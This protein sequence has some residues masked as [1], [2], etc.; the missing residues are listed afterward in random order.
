MTTASSIVLHI[1]ANDTSRETRTQI[2]RDAGFHV[3]EDLGG[4]LASALAVTHQPAL[5]LLDL[6][7]PDRDG[8]QLCRELKQSA[9]AANV[10]VLAILAEEAGENACAIAAEFGADACLREPVEPAVL[11]S[12]VRALIGRRQAVPETKQ[13]D[14]RA[15]LHGYEVHGGAELILGSI[16]DP[17]LAL[18]SSSRITYLNAAAARLLS[19]S[20]DA[21]LGKNV[22]EAYPD[23]V[24][25]PIH[26]EYLKTIRD[27]H[28]SSLRDP[29]GE[30]AEVVRCSRFPDSRRR[31]YR[32]FPRYYGTEAG[33]IQA[34]ESQER[35]KLATEGAG[36][37]AGI[38]I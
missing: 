5:I 33:R 10:P 18:D 32:P 19:R 4:E 17:L 24:G 16:T 3:V 27:Q 20:A 30:L 15:D 7:L 9:E 36:L 23:A 12:T 29:L 26:R 11:M 14:K 1:Y 38:S 37:A 22:W 21:L 34:H 6:Q 8:C 13:R 2:L 31:H 25:T 35:L 28:T